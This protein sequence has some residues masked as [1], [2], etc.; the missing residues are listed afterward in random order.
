MNFWRKIMKLFRGVLIVLTVALVFQALLTVYKHH[1]KAEQLERFVAAEALDAA[2]SLANALE[3]TYYQDG[4]LDSVVTTCASSEITW[5]KTTH[6][7]F[8]TRCNVTGDFY[9]PDTYKTI[10]DGKDTILPVS[11]FT[12]VDERMLVRLKDGWRL[13]SATLTVLAED[14]RGRVL[15]K[16]SKHLR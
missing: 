8:T 14:A 12:R 3:A 1:K 2:A 9:D 15:A 4:G 13:R 5:T 6:G 16:A 11:L 10:T 7:E